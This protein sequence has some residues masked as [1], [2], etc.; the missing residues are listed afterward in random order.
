MTLNSGQ[1]RMELHNAPFSNHF[2]AQ[3]KHATNV[4]HSMSQ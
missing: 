2:N 4:T 3:P 1:L